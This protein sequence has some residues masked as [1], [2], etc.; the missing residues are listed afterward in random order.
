MFE[1]IIVLSDS[2]EIRSY[3]LINGVTTYPEPEELATATSYVGEAI[4]EFCGCWHKR[5]DYMQL[6]E[7]TNPLIR[8]AM[9]RNACKFIQDKDAD[10]IIGMCEA[11]CPSGVAKP[12]P[13]GL[14]VTDWW[15]DELWTV[16]DQDCEQ[17][18]KVSGLIYIGKWWVWA[19]NVNYWKTKIYAFVHDKYDSVDID[20]HR[21]LEHA[22]TLLRKRLKKE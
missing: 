11:G 22:E 7:P 10:F 5:Y 3:A 14:C 20:Y 2:K 17:A 9:I 4:Q 19:E 16:R 15:P 8:P 6:I 12:L 1:D 13:A 18:Y 21:D